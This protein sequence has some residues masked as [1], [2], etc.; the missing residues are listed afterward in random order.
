M[1]SHDDRVFAADLFASDVKDAIRRDDL[2]EALTHAR[3]VVVLLEALVVPG[4]ELAEVAPEPP[5]CGHD[6]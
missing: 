3:S 4:E 1:V 5:E 6:V 2:A